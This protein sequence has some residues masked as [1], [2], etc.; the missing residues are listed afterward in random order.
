MRTTCS[1]D[2]VLALLNVAQEIAVA[3]SVQAA[4]LVS[5]ALMQVI[6][7]NKQEWTSE[8]MLNDTV[9]FTEMYHVS[10]TVIAQSAFQ[11]KERR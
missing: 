3:I 4:A 6:A 9:W 1:S 8:G 11:M 7:Q 10:Y 2:Q 5:S